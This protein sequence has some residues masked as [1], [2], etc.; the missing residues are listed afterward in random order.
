[1]S[2]TGGRLSIVHAN[3]AFS[4][5]QMNAQGHK[6]KRHKH[7][8]KHQRFLR[9]P[10]A[11]HLGMQGTGSRLGAIQ[12]LYFCQNRSPLGQK[13]LFFI[14]VVQ[15]AQASEQGLFSPKRR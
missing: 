14:A 15:S 9:A 13:R 6:P 7:H 8:K 3:V 4:A 11:R 10:Q 12:S 2:Q 1:M 5:D